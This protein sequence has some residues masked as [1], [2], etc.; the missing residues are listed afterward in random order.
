M[1]ARLRGNL[2]EKSA[3]RIVLDVHGVGYEVTIPF[4]TYYELPDVGQEVSLHI[5]THVREDALSLFG[6]RTRKEKEIFQHLIQIA[7]IGP[8]L[9]V[10]ILSGLPIDE[11]LQA[12]VG[13]DVARLCSIPGVGKKTA[14]RVVLELRERLGSLAEGVPGGGEVVADPV[15]RD[16]SSAL[17]NLGY[18]RA[19]A[20][21]V[22]SRLLREG[23]WDSFEALLKGALKELAG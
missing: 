11:L 23:T 3:D 22:V 16:V 7:G 19:K 1:I 20:E 5:Y 18:P 8:R 15:A 21:S 9:A 10:T 17:I 13:G 4:S 14:E 6:F 2:L 12:I